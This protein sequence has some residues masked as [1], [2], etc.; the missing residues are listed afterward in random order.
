MPKLGPSARR[1]IRI[2]NPSDGGLAYWLAKLYSFAGLSALSIGLYGLL[3]VYVRFTAQLPPLP[4][5][6]HYADDAPG[7]TTLL[8]QDG[9]LLAELSTQRRELVAL[10]RVPQK[11]VDAFVATEDRRFFS[12]GGIDLRGTLRA[13]VTNLRAGGVAQGGS[14]ITQQVAKSYLSS[15]RSFS[16]KI[17]E[18]LL[19]R[20]LEARY[21]KREILALYLNQIYLGNGAYGVQAAARRYF[22]KDVSELDL[23]EMAMIAGL[24]QAPSRDSPMVDERAAAKRRGQVLANLA[25]VG[26]ITDAEAQRW[27]AT[28]LQIHPRRDY[29][30]EVSPYF[31]EH[32]R[33][34][35]VRSW[36][37]KEYLGQGLRIGDEHERRKAVQRLGEKWLYE[38]GY[39]VETTDLPYL[40]LLAQ[41]NVDVAV[42]KLDKRQG[43]RGPEAQL[44]IGSATAEM[45]RRRARELY[46]EGPLVEGKLYLGLVEQVAEQ[47]RV[48]VGAN[49]YSLPLSN[50][51]WASRFSATDAT[52]DKTIGSV[53]EAL[54]RGDVIWVRWA[55][56]SRIPRYSDFTYNEE[57]DALWLPE[58]PYRKPP[59]GPQVL[60]LDQAPRVSGSLY[61]FDHHNG[62]VLAM[63]GGD[64]FDQ[65]EFNRVVQ[66]CRQPGSAYKPIYYSLALDRGYSFDTLWNDRPKAEVDPVTGELWVPENIDGSYGIQVTMERALVWSKNPP[67]GEIYA[68]LGTKSVDEWHKRLGFSTPLVP[69]EVCYKKYCPSLALGASCVHMDDL[70]R[71]FAVFARNGRPIETVYVRRV[72]DRRGRVIED[73]TAWDDPIL[74]GGA[75]LDRIAARFGDEPGPVIAPRTAWLTTK[76]L[77]EIVTQGHSAPI[78]AVKIPSAGKTGTSSRTSDVWFVG[79]TSK[80]LTTA[81]IG[82]DTYERQLGF[83]DASFMLSVPMWARY[84]ASAVGDQPLEE[85]PWETPPGAKKNDRGGPLKPGFPPPPALGVSPDGKAYQLPEKY[86]AAQVKTSNEPPQNLAPQKIIRFPGGPQKPLKPGGKPTVVPRR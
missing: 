43:W 66:S 69:S 77:R 45:F 18:A 60:A 61:T 7:I 28:P 2:A 51:A 52:N 22:D 20:R 29:F 73:H 57:G 25:A 83:K 44:A 14:T 6:A 33:R 5:L 55:Y 17:R 12:H 26:A 58:Q 56:H 24:A 9:T 68:T 11:L 53:H 1:R 78:R 40:D 50:M 4:D 84:M 65:S 41:E 10:D 34:E 76:L 35:L 42:R 67:S 82:D 81:W 59:P 32:V 63:A 31:A 13:L 72:I 19:A 23:G 3:G 79:F 38:G 49:L 39:R 86:K 80:W 48:R 27:T 75:R 54:K 74:D 47:A 21:S 46:G 70:S 71:A 30:H 8:G 36:G 64:D 85:I 37:E 15:E 16:R 62:Y